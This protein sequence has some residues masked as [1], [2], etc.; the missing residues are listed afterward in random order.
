M[1]NLESP[2]ETG[3]H[4]DGIGRLVLASASPRRRQILSEAGLDFEVR[5]STIEE[6]ARAGESPENLA[7]RLA[8]EKALDVA[9]A[10]SRGEQPGEQLVHRIKARLRGFPSDPSRAGAPHY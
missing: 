6:R 9:H 10:L 5:P 4:V 7:E 3:E 2:S 8:R 1:K